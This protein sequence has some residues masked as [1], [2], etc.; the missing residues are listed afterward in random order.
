MVMGPALPA[1]GQTNMGGWF[2]IE[3]GFQF[4]GFYLVMVFKSGYGMALEFVNYSG[5][6]QAVTVPMAAR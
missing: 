3:K 1:I 5:E 2:N 4:N 6:H